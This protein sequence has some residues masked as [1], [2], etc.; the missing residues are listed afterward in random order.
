[1]AE[2]IWTPQARADVEAIEAY[3][4]EVAPAY[5]DVVVDGLLSSTR[6]LETFPRS[7]RAV[8]EVADAAIREVI[9]RDYRV[10]HYVDGEAERVEVLAVLHTS[11]QFGAGSGAEE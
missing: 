4:L 9:W 6:R 10:I 1:M 3:Y 8:P 5:A 11:R 2:V 7:G